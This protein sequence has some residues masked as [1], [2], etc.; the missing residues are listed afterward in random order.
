MKVRGTVLLATTAA[1]LGAG[2]PAAFRYADSFWLYR[3][4]PPPDVKQAIREVQLPGSSLVPAASIPR[5]TIERIFVTSPALGGRQQP[6][7][8]YLPAGY[9][10][11]PAERYPVLYLLHGFPSSPTTWITVGRVGLLQDIL[12]AEG[13]MRP[14]IEVMP[15]GST[16]L[17]R[18]EEWANAVTPAN[19]WETFVA[20]DVVGTIDARFRTISAGQGRALIGLSEG[21][22]GALNIG[23]HHPGEFDVIESW[24]GYVWA[25][26]IARIF[27]GNERLLAANSPM[28]T[29]RSVAPVL[30][31][32]HTLIWFYCGFNDR[33]LYQN[34]RFADELTQLGIDHQF[35]WAGGGHTWS[36]WRRFAPEALLVA[37]R[38]LSGYG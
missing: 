4:F 26:D 18:D 13:R 34:K 38:H 11:H 20:R 16:S 7:W 23:L 33:L 8:V 22:Y 21:A 24:S 14:A 35:F 31:A 5:G 36:L 9:T 17:I 2:L 15:F 32:S 29:V 6:V 10:N 12:V 27:G 37:S 25:D 3:G 19:Q 1:F 28:L 30:R